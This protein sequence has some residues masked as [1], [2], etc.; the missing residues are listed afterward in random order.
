MNNTSDGKRML[1]VKVH[2]GANRNKITSFSD[3]ILYVKIS[4]PPD[5]GKANLELIDFLSRS[6]GVSKSSITIIKGTTTRNKLISI[7]NLPP[8]E[9]IKRLSI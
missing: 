1:P 9:I 6:L 4:A 7:D 8:E 5:K 3:G 2:P